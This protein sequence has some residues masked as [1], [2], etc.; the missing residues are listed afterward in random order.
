[1]EAC[2]E[3]YRLDL[4]IPNISSSN[5]HFDMT[6]RTQNADQT[7]ENLEVID[8]LDGIDEINSSKDLPCKYPSH[9]NSGI[10]ASKLTYVNDEEEVN[11]E[12]SVINAPETTQES[13]VAS[14][15]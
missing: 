8:A 1:M 6:P 4:S 2:L 9:I 14:P 5:E 11:C 12:T 15:H 10:L 3:T 7:T 13:F